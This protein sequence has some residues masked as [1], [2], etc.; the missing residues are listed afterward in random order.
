MIAEEF[1]LVLVNRS[2]GS[3]TFTVMVMD[4]VPG[5]AQ[6]RYSWDDLLKGL[7]KSFQDLKFQRKE[8]GTCGGHPALL[9]TC[10]GVAQERQ[11]RWLYYLVA[12]PKN[13]YVL[14]WISNPGEYP[15]LEPVFEQTVRGFALTR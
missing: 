14:S 6:G 7:T 1:A 2:R 4:P 11:K 10:S 15:S 12:A 3:G 8:P 9:T 5:I 13:L